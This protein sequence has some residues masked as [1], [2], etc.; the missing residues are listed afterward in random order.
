M[1]EAV[2]ELSLAPV[3]DV[4]GAAVPAVHARRT[5]R[6]YFLLGFAALPWFWVCNIWLYWPDFWHA[7]D[8]VVAK[9][10]PTRLA[11][12]WRVYRIFCGLP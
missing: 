4:D 9:C 8:A 12:C 6:L 1:S 2:G 10:K 11:R 3:E 5:A 7:R